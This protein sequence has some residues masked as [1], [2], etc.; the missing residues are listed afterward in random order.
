MFV[1]CG[2]SI[3]CPCLTGST[4]E[5]SRFSTPETLLV[6]VM[7]I[8]LRYEMVAVA[9]RKLLKVE[10]LELYQRKRRVL[11]FSCLRARLLSCETKTEERVFVYY[12]FFSSELCSK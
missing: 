11:F 5:T 1:P 8:V 7:R 3:F 12:C 2:L 4:V 10:N 6:Y 9:Y